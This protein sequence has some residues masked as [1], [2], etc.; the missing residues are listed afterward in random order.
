MTADNNIRSFPYLIWTFPGCLSKI[1][2]SATV[3]EV[4]RALR[5]YGWTVD[6]LDAGLPI[7]SNTIQGVKVIHL[8]SPDIYFFRQVIL[9]LHMCE[10]IRNNWD[11]I[12]IVF[13]RPQSTPWMLILKSKRLLSG[14]RRPLFVMDTRTVQMEGKDQ[15]NLRIRIHGLFDKLMGKIANTFADG[16][17]AITTRLAEAIR[18]P[19]GKLW[20]TWPSGVDVEKFASANKM[21]KWPSGEEPVHL[22]YLGSLSYERN[23]MVLCQA[24]EIANREGMHLFLTLLGDGSEREDLEVF[25]RQTDGR[26]QVLLPVPHDEVP[27]ILGKMHVGVLPFPDEPKFQISSPIKL[28]EYMGAGMPILATHIACHT[29]V[30]DDG[31]YVFWAE[32]SD[33]LG[34]YD[35]L[36]EVWQQRG[37]LAEKGGKSLIASRDW[38]WQRSA[39]K[40]KKALEYGLSINK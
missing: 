11:T 34:L 27:G 4:T 1:L 15:L 28:F 36:C 23:I 9:H 25:A 22:I 10:F 40:L 37:L 3:L 19:P 29:D 18:I 13:F 12:D 6:L 33:V 8:S 5:K 30:I 39:E 2:D 31:D 21:R 14:K 16:Q 20:G 35:A 32:K 7:G 38:T 17:T 26:I 24:V